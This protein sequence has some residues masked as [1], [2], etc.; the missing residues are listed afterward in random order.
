MNKI[1]V[2]FIGCGRISDLHYPGY[3]NN[4]DARIYA[5]C[6]SNE[7]TAL[8][9]KKQW[10]AARH[11]TDY[12]EMLEDPEIDAVEILTPHT[13]HESMVIDSA[14]AYKHI[15]VQKPMA[16]NL[17]SADRMLDYA[18]GRGRVFRVTDNYAFYPPVIL[19][20]K[21]IDSGDI[22]TPTNIRIKLLSGGSGGWEI[23]PEAWEWRVREND[24]GNGMRG[25][26]TFDHGHHLWTTAWYL[27][28][29]IERVNAWIDS[30]DGII[31]SPAVIMWKHSNGII[32]GS[33]EYAHEPDLVIPSKYYAND[34]WIEISGT[35]GVIQI[36][37]C[38]GNVQEGPPVSLFNSRGWKHYSRVKCDWKEGFIG[39]TNNFI[40][41]IKGDEE[42]LLSGVQAREILRFSL[43]IQKSARTRREVYTGELDSAWPWL[44]TWNKIRADRKKASTRRGLLALLGMGKGDKQYA[45]MAKDLTAELVEKY[46][47]DAVKNWKCSIGLNLVQDGQ[48]PELNFSLM[49]NSGVLTFTE[50]ELPGSPDLVI[51]VPAGT[52][53][54]ILL[55]KKRIET[56]FIQGRIKMEGRAEEAL[57]LRS[58]FGI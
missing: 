23:P 47:P 18:S 56:A 24:Q 15:A 36:H 22:G 8:Q 17:K 26:Q 31:D 35:R 37:R 7:E 1:N 52:W 4:R 40:N 12:R 3:R 13:L 51:K 41:S 33:C 39:A 32:Y 9:R 45:S 11:F 10:K 14:N 53:A 29:G 27:L 16:V 6:D 28:G 20:R 2:G 25:L 55:G 54:A 19:A 58:A 57:K 48:A 42:P 5:V 44:Y 34:E 50:G 49:I 43:S 21:M 30:L 38:T 46:D